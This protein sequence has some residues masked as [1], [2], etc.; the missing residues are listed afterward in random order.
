MAVCMAEILADGMA[1]RLAET[2]AVCEHG[3]ILHFILLIPHMNNRTD[4]AQRRE[5]KKTLG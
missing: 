1:D 4:L 5:Q 3:M 2:V